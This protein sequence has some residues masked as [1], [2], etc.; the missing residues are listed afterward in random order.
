[1]SNFQVRLSDIIL[2]STLLTLRLLDVS[3][4]TEGAFIGKLKERLGMLP[5]GVDPVGPDSVWPR[6]GALPFEY[7][8]AVPFLPFG[9]PENHIARFGSAYKVIETTRFVDLTHLVSAFNHF[10]LMKN[11][12]N[13]VFTDLQGEFLT[14]PLNDSLVLNDSRL[15]RKR[16]NEIDALRSSTLYVRRKCWSVGSWPVLYRIV[17]AA[18]C[19]QRQQVL[20]SSRSSSLRG[21]G[22]HRQRTRSSRSPSFGFGRRTILN[23]TN[24]IHY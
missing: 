2:Q 3:W 22:Y 8:L 14:F 11:Q 1:M 5:H 17:H 23:R 19:M 20:R 18:S 12:N 13:L 4:N 24:I 7:F 15:G 10:S 6:N 9:D 16:R 21:P